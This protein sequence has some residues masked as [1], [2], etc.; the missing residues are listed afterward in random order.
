MDKI[1]LYINKTVCLIFGHKWFRYFAFYN[2]E[3]NK[4]SM[5]SECVRCN[6]RELDK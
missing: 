2:L 5:I 6:K 4:V 1:A 3:D